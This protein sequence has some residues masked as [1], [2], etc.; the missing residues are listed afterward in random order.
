MRNTK[1]ISKESITW[2]CQYAQ[3]LAYK[4][5]TS[6]SKQIA[7]SVPMA[8]EME[9]GKVEFLLKWTPFLSFWF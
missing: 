9:G 2:L 7:K 8:W 5:Q 3:V 4:A 1:T 6:I